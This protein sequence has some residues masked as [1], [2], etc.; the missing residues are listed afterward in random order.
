MFVRKRTRKLKSGKMSVTY[1]A[2]ESYRKGKKVKQRVISLGK[3]ENPK[4]ALNMEIKYAER[5]KREL[6]VPFT[7][8]KEL[9]HIVG[10]GLQL[11]TLPVKEAEKR[12]RKILKR[13]EKH[14]SRIG[15]LDDM[16]SKCQPNEYKRDTTF[17]EKEAKAKES[18]EI[19]KDIVDKY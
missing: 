15:M 7:E 18:L 9:K 6:T 17:S 10:L 5:A 2:V 4:D 19:L 12:R 16:A 11:L 1:Q 14:R 13:Y 3:F 8:Y